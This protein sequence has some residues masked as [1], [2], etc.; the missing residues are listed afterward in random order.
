M[1]NN[2]EYLIKSF[3]ERPKQRAMLLTE[4]PL[5]TLHLIQR[6]QQRQ[7]DPVQTIYDVLQQIIRAEIRS[8]RARLI[9]DIPAQNQVFEADEY[10]ILRGMGGLK[11][12]EVEQVWTATYHYYFEQRYSSMTELA[13]VLAL[14]RNTVSA[15][16]SRGCEWMM[17]HLLAWDSIVGLD[18][19]Q[20]D[21]LAVHAPPIQTLPLREVM[22]YGQ[23]Q[24]T[25]SSGCGKTTLAYQTAENLLYSRQVAAVVWLTMKG[26]ESADGLSPDEATTMLYRRVSGNF[27]QFPELE[28]QWEHL[29][30]ALAPFQAGPQ[31]VVLD[32]MEVMDEADIWLNQLAIRLPDTRLL[33]TTQ[34]AII[35]IQNIPVLPVK[36][37]NLES[38]LRHQVEAC[39]I[40]EQDNTPSIA[41]IKQ[42]SRGLPLALNFLAHTFKTHGIEATAKTLNS[43]KVDDE[44]PLPMVLTQLYQHVWNSLSADARRLCISMLLC[45][46]KEGV[47][48]DWLAWLSRFGEI[49]YPTESLGKSRM[50]Q[51]LPPKFGEARLMAKAYLLLNGG[52][53][54][55][56]W[57]TRRFLHEVVHG[58]TTDNL[59]KIEY[60]YQQDRAVYE[61]A[62]MVK[63]NHLPFLLVNLPHLIYL[64]SKILPYAKTRPEDKQLW[65]VWAELIDVMYEGGQ[66]TDALNLSAELMKNYATA[67]SED[68]KAALARVAWVRA[69]IL[70]SMYSTN[71]IPSDLVD[72]I[73]GDVLGKEWA[74]AISYGREAFRSYAANKYDRAYSNCRRAIDR[75]KGKPDHYA[76]PIIGLQALAAWGQE[77]FE[78]AIE[79]FEMSRKFYLE[80]GEYIRALRMQA[81]LGLVHFS[82]QSFDLAV[83]MLTEALDN[84]DRFSARWLEAGLTGNLALCLMLRGDL[85]E[86]QQMAIRHIDRAT[87]LKAGTRERGR[88]VAHEG[89]IRLYSGDVIEAIQV[90]KADAEWKRGLTSDGK[91]QEDTGSQFRRDYMLLSLAYAYTI[92]G[93]LPLAVETMNTFE[94]QFEEAS[95]KALQVLHWRVK[96]LMAET[97]E[98]R[99]RLLEECIVMAGNIHR[100]LDEAACWLMRAAIFPVERD[101]HI[102]TALKLLDAAGATGWAARVRAGELPFIALMY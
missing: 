39:I 81:E 40:L 95:I 89:L 91:P 64:V 34:R 71:Q 86:A 38:Y 53:I 96:A 58:K 11:L 45:A 55:T 61:L 46:P 12:Q 13:T 90:I 26:E 51:S 80:Q 24:L 28:A 54:Q 74:D 99:A 47:S 56:H 9:P 50:R 72:P 15:W 73:N 93:N 2:H 62:R 98:Q 36:D 63:L 22:I 16:L 10:Y 87:S 4:A 49:Q 88:A 70:S 17:E 3:L 83:Q 85:V 7:S 48:D 57:H 60:D 82:N 8:I 69:D 59:A 94:K 29:A 75:L 5:N 79:L 67:R 27:R 78:E 41:E 44:A 35:G 23:S 31:L 20:V 6:A 92:T 84:C 37:Q 77:T 68:E 14:N 32:G 102:A 30:T 42:W 66:W 100:P 33:M 21:T 76:L 43:T 52:N 65:L 101:I 25:G 97:N 1:P 19:A 18:N